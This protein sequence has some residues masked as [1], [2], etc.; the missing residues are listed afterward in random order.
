[1]MMTMT[2][3]D[4]NVMNGDGWLVGLQYQLLRSD[5]DCCFDFV[6]DC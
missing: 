5:D 1:M 6:D 3:L 2:L 4:C